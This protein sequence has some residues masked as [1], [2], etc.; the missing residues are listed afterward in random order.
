MRHDHR[1]FVIVGGGLAGATAAETLRNRG[2]SGRLVVFAAEPHFPYERPPLSKSYLSGAAT[3]EQLY[4]RPPRWYVDNDV[5][6]LLASPATD[7]DLD[8][9]T[10]S[11]GSQTIGFDKLLLT[12]G[13][14][15]RRLPLADE[16]GAPVAYLR[17]IDDSRRLRERLRPECRLVVVGGGWLGLEV[18]AAARTSGSAV[19]VVEPLQQPLLRV[20][21]PELAA[22]FAELHTGHGVDLRTE[23]SVV[24]IDG[25]GNRAQVYLDDGAVLPA[26]LV[27][28]AIGAFPNTELADAAGVKTDD[29]IVVDEHL[30][31]SAQDVF[32]AGDVANAYHPHLGHY[33]RVEH[34][35]NAVGQ[36]TNAALNMKGAGISYTRLPYFYTDQYDLGMEYVGH[37]G[38]DGYDDVVIRGD[39][40]RRVF[41]AFWIQ[42]STVL[43]GMHVNDWDAMAAI[44]RI[45]AAPRVDVT[46]LT[47]PRLP[48]G[49]LASGTP[50]EE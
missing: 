5:E 34:W 2:F 19:T 37:V 38:P 20:L 28:V 30:Q 48:L 50:G 43:A 36:G 40:H 8:A 26:D 15:P 32:A 14:S 46:T 27:L 4:A 10:V 21:G 3:L 33:L 35:D 29:G 16:S 6:L 13:A 31:T 41:S 44:R 49:S 42:G 18:A 9:H 12:T 7:R 22:V 23:R 45:V 17:T 24:G 11:S 1:T 25:D 47:D 39:V